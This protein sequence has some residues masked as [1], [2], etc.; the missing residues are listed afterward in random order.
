MRRFT[1]DSLVGN[2]VDRMSRSRSKA[3]TSKEAE[4]LFRDAVCRVQGRI[5]LMPTEGRYH[6]FPRRLEDDYEM[7][8]EKLGKGCSGPVYLARSWL[9][10]AQC[11]VKTF[12]LRGVSVE[13]R[14][15]LVAEVEIFLSMDRPH[16]ARLLEVYESLGRLSLVMECLGVDELFKRVKEK[17][18][19]SEEEAAL[20]TRQMLLS[21]GYLH[22]EGVVHGDLKLA[23]FI[24]E[25]NRPDFLKLIDFGFSKFYPKKNQIN[26]GGGTIDCCAPER[27][28]H[29]R[30]TSS[31]DMWSIGVL[32]YI[33]LAGRMP[34]FGPEV[35]K[36]ILRGKY[37]RRAGNIANISADASDFVQKLLLVDA[38]ARMTGEQ[39]LLHPWIADRPGRPK[40]VPSEVIQDIVGAMCKFAQEPKFNRQC[41]QMMA[42]SLSQEER[43]KFDASDVGVIKL[44][45]LHDM[46]VRRLEGIETE[47]EIA[48]ISRV[49]EELDTDAN[50]ETRYSDFLAAM[51]CSQL[52][53]KDELLRETFRR[54]DSTKSGFITP[55]S[56]RAVLGA[57][58][59]VDSIIEAVGIGSKGII[60]EADFMSYMR[61]GRHQRSRLDRS[62]ASRSTTMCSMQ[63]LED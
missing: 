30:Y 20:A 42:W 24:Y 10:G 35:G 58:A 52:S 8:T 26:G 4:Q 25:K 9:T 53:L 34:F 17:G 54:F 49:F 6:Q 57:S 62:M 47:E 61:G 55:E 27:L 41:F 59:D 7:S 63:S 38:N 11:A 51:M 39:A 43:S 32:V 14:D 1:C 13:E 5:G 2:Y 46:I 36:A 33:L 48:N 50:R 23:H 19:F 3:D 15:A 31:A 60:F 29:G 37:N 21:V 44:S 12:R 18:H 16:V 28:L 56:L 22:N 45:K 40:A